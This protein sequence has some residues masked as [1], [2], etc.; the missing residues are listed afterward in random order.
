ML[1]F[2]IK[3]GVRRSVAALAAGKTEIAAVVM[4]LGKPDEFLTVALSELYS[5]KPAIA[6]DYRYIVDTEY[7]TMVL[8]TNPPEIRVVRIVSAVRMKRLTH[9]PRVQLV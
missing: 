8:G 9:L 3:E 5:P 1:G 4:E 6:R 2:E 7:P